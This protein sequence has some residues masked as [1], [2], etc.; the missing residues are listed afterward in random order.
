MW[1]TQTYLTAPAH[2][3]PA[4]AYF[5]FNPYTSWRSPVI[6][7]IRDGLRVLGRQTEERLAILMPD[8]DIDRQKIGK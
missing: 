7:A 8:E 2:G 4:Y 6:R 5:L 3:F 1:L